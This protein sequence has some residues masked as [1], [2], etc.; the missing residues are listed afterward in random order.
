[1]N[2]PVC[3]NVRKV[4]CEGEVT[5]CPVCEEFIVWREQDEAD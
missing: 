4:E 2:C 3:S 5:D 1:M